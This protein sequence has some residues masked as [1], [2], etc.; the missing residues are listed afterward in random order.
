[1]EEQAYQP[2]SHW[3]LFVLGV[4]M[5][6]ISITVEASTHI[7][8]NVFFDPLPTTWHLLLVIF[9][10][11]AQL[12]VWFAIRRGTPDRLRLAGFINAIVIGISI[13]YSIVYLP[14]LPLGLMTLIIGLGFLPLAP[15]FSL[16]GALLMRHRMNQIA[17]TSPPKTFTVKKRGLLV[18]LGVT[19]VVLGVIELPA[20][21]TRIGL[22]KAVSDSPQTRAEGIRFLRT[23]GSKDALLRSCYSQS[24]IATDLFGYAWLMGTPINPNEARHIYYRV[25][26]ET[27]DSSL[28]PDRIGGRLIP[29]DT[30]DFDNDQGGSRISGKLKGLSLTNS[31]L[32]ASVDANGG[33]GYMEWT[34]DFRNESTDQREARAEVQLP[35]GGVVSRLTLWVN[36]EPREAAFAGRGKVTRA[37]QQV[38]IRERRDPV[39]VTT[40]G[41]DRIMVQCFPVPANGGEMK[42][43]FGI[44]L[45]LPLEEPNR[46]QLLLPYFANRNFRIADDVRH[47][48]TINSKTRLWP[49]SYASRNSQDGGESI[50]ER[51]ISD[52]ELS[53][54]RSAI[55]VER[56]DVKEMWSKDPFEK[57]FMVQQKIEER[58]PAHLQRIVLVVDTS[59]TMHEWKSDLETAVSL[60]PPEFDVK[61]VL[62]DADMIDDFKNLANGPNEIQSA[63]RYANYAGGADNMP[64]LLKAWDL[65][66]EKPGNNAI[67]WIHDPQRLLIRSSEELRQRWNNRPYGPT[68][69]SVQATRGA[70]EIEKSL[71][72][73]DEVK[74]VARTGD[75]DEDLKY[76]FARLT[77]SMKTYAFVRSSK[78]LDEKQV[79]EAHETSDHLARLWAN[80]EVARILAPRDAELEDEAITLAARYQLVTPVTGAVVLETEQQYKANDLK[81]VDAGTVPTIPEPEMVVLFIVAGAFM[82][83]LAYMKYRKSGPGR[84]SV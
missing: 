44:T 45:P 27:F 17:A 63:L 58:T 40:A 28:P 25:T 66:A 67:V 75:L 18:G 54:A 36:G 8:A 59:K 80:D 11:L 22:Q 76:L 43:R 10:P 56:A 77:G 26:G 52:A 21:L 70:D 73:I 53:E 71:D 1:M 2:K 14:I 74:S 60:L 6:A 69:Y 31:K 72:G 82:L 39:L 13:F 38:A 61:L 68:L 62:A 49:L 50:L 9:V 30:V 57:G 15:Y 23:Y 55:L 47:A 41:R 12:Q 35:P 81:P 42:I 34:L 83:W 46:A 3:F 64:A 16:I 37:Y 78:K 5:P 33:V 4:I 65:A 29:Q 32:E 48:V 51:S 24:G 84:C 19:L 20:T 79:L 7:C